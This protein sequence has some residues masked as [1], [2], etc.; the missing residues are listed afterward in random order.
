M[1]HRP[2]PTRVAPLAPDQGAA[3]ARNGYLLLRGVVPEAWRC[4]PLSMP[5]S[6]RA[7]HGRCPAAPRRVDSLWAKRKSPSASKKTS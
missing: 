3:L 5:V 2:A 4:A 1:S 6:G 7:T